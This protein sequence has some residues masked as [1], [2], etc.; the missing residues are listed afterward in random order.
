MAPFMPEGAV[1]LAGILNLTLPKGGPDGGPDGWHMLSE[2]LQ[3]G[4]PLGVPE[5][6]FPKLDKDALAELADAHLRGEAY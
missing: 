6:L 5:V 4:A 1:K 2:P 3:A